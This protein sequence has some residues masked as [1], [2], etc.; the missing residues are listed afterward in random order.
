MK[1]V[2]VIA[3]LVVSLSARADLPKEMYMA[4]DAGGFVV[5][6][7]EPCAFVNVSKEYP[8]KAYATESS[9]IVNHAGCWNTPDTSDVP[10]ELYSK[11]EGA[12][13]PPTIRVIRMVNTWWEEGGRASFLQSNFTPEKKRH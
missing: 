10:T 6:T 13:G 9:D 7:V 8:Y 3:L 5:L 11:P 12:G 1:I 2:A 4:N